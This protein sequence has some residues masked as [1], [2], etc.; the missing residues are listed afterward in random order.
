M[1]WEMKHP[2]ATLDMLG[3]I[4]SFLDEND[5]RP[6]AKQIDTAYVGGWQPFPGFTMV[7]NG[8]RY[9]GDPLTPLLAETKLRDETIRFYDCSWVAIVQPDGSYEI[10]RLD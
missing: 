3:Y 2:Q 8:L 5:P 9:P 6:A 4:P 7:D 1:K 10:S